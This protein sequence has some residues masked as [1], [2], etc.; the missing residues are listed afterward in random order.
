MRHFS[1]GFLR[2]RAYRSERED[3]FGLNYSMES[4]VY[5]IKKKNEEERK[6]CKRFKIC[7]L[8]LKPFLMMVG[9]GKNPNF[10]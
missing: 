3:N 7:K 1:F 6:D 9:F 8:N 5:V 2:A 10:V 4:R